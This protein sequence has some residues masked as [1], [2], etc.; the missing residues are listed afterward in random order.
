MVSLRVGEARIE[1]G[2]NAVIASSEAVRKFMLGL[3]RIM[4][5]RG[6]WRVFVYTIGLSGCRVTIPAAEK[7]VPF[8]RCS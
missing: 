8:L 6:N 5:A 1:V 3:H 7:Y 4:A 2:K